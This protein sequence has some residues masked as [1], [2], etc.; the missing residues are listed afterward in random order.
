VSRPPFLDPPVGVRAYRLHTR[1]GAFAV[2]DAAPA[3][4]G[5]LAGTA[6]LVPGY[7]GSKEDFIAL[8]AP[9][10]EAGYRAVAVDGRG[11]YETPGDGVRHAYGLGALAEDVLAQAEALEPS[12]PPHLVGHSLGGLIARGAV[13]RAAAR[14]RLPF[15]SLTLVGSGPARVARWPRWRLRALNAGLPVL[16]PRAMWRVWHPVRERDDTGRWM[17]G[18]WLASTP[19]QARVTGRTLRY[20]PDRVARLV[21]TGLPVHVVSGERDGAWPVPLLDRMAHRLNA[22]RTVI[23]GAEHSPNTEEPLATAAA[24]ADFW[25]SCG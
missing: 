21:A 17:R 16:G 8:L 5:P 25:R 4:G 24:L 14:G 9:L 23:K 10:A 20:E 18:R 15:A 7:T 2:L 22:R 12:S 6:L 19:V 1:R 11:Q 3:D 13:L